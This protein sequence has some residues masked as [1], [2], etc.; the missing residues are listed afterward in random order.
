MASVHL[1]VMPHFLL[2]F[3]DMILIYASGSAAVV[4]CL[5]LLLSP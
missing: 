4:I 1:D 2:G 5:I 3:H